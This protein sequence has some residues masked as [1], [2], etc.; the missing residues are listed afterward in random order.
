MPR[1]KR[2]PKPSIFQT[3]I[4]AMI[5]HSPLMKTYTADRKVVWGLTNGR[6]ISDKCAETLI[7]N[8]WVV[9]Q[10]DGLDMFDETQTYTA[11]KP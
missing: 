11:R 7:R 5:A 4:L 3:G 2:P 1:N 6:E 10:R 9:P 8:G